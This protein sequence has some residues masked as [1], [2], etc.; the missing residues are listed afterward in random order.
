MKYALVINERIDT[1]SY[2]PQDGWEQVSDDVFAG[3]VKNGG[4]WVPPPQSD[5]EVSAIVRSRR[6][7]LIEQTDWRALPDV[8][9]RDAWLS[10]R[11][12]LRDIPQQA[13]FPRNVVWPT[14][15]E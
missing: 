5:E 3:F 1:I 2:Q 7:L 12:A 10:Y 15:P 13:G 9:G 14:K 11:Q 6:D 8:P 4:A